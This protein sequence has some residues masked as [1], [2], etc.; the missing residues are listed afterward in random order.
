MQIM[1]DDVDYKKLVKILDE[2]L[3]DVYAANDFEVVVPNCY[4]I[5]NDILN[6]LDI[7]IQR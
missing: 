6:F 1:I 7:E 2:Y 3:S 5:I 4:G